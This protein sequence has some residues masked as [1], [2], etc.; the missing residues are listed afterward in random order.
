M[1]IERFECEDNY[2]AEKL[3]GLLTVQKDNSIFVSGIA[4]A[5]KNEIVVLLKDKSSHSVILKDNNN[6]YRLKSLIE[7]VVI[8]KKAIF[9]TTYENCTTQ[10][11]ISE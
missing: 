1:K 6:V 8:G 7:E 10:V 4:A 2:E 5:I 11:I 3:A 9:E